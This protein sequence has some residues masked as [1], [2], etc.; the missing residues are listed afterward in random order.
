MVKLIALIFGGLMTNDGLTDA[1]RFLPFN[2]GGRIIQNFGIDESGDGFQRNL[3]L[4]GNPLS[5]GGGL[6]VFGG[7]VLVL[8]VGSLIAFNKRDA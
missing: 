7:L 4:F 6:I 8:M 1:T 5:A 3:D 2:A